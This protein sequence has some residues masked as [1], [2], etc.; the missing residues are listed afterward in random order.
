MNR[1]W[2]IPFLSGLDDIGEIR[3]LF[4][5][6][7]S[8]YVYVCLT[9]L[10]LWNSVSLP[11]FSLPSPHFCIHTH[12]PSF[13]LLGPRFPLTFS[14]S[15]AAHPAQRN[16][17]LCEGEHHCRQPRVGVWPYGHNLGAGVYSHT[18][19]PV[20]CSRCTWY[21]SGTSKTWPWSST[22]CSPESHWSRNVQS[23]WPSSSQSL[24]C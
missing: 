9:L 19:R 21:F 11:T 14:V 22:L 1:L 5:A 17:L 24:Y 16:S 8:K 13:A 6:E 7:V 4:S 12:S 2:K 23:N 10:A 20:L 15:F 3:T 18:C